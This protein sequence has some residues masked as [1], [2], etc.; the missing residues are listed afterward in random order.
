MPITINGS[1]TLTGVSVGGLPDGIVD[2]D[3]IADAAVT[4][5]KRGPGS[6]L[7]VVSTEITG[8]IDSN[9]ST[10]VASGLITTLTPK[11]TNSKFYITVDNI[12]GHSNRTTTT[13]NGSIYYLYVSVNGGTYANAAADRLS[14]TYINGDLG[15]WLDFP[16]SIS[17][18][19]TP[20]YS[21]GQT[22]AYQPY[23]VKG[24][25]NGVAGYFN[26]TGG[27]GTNQRVTQI[28]M[29]IAQ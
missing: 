12:C 13:N 3:M 6:V 19:D 25:N 8:N 26:H 5:V 23:Y 16:T 24:L 15:N 11:Q 4:D 14:S 28:V 27:N 18:F 21:A 17:Y 22:V 29:E 1:G 2:T 10:A 7:Q 20:S 9:S